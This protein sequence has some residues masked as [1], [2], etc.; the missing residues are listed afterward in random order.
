MIYPVLY[1]EERLLGWAGGWGNVTQ[2]GGQEDGAVP[3]ELGWRQWLA[4]AC[5][6]PI[7]HP[8]AGA[9]EMGQVVRRPSC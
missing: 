2:A 6:E 9:W 3:G 4:P 8:G 1:L 5:S 7:R